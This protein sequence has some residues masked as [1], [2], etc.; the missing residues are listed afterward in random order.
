MSNIKGIFY[1]ISRQVMI[2]LFYIKK[3]IHNVSNKK[4]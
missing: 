1:I 4:F 2:Y 3:F